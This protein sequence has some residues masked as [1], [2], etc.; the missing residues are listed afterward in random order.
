MLSSGSALGAPTCSPSRPSVP[1]RRS[2]PYP[3]VPG[4]TSVEQEYLKALVFQASSMDS[5]LPLEIEIAERFIAH[6]L[7]QFVFYRRSEAGQRVLGGCR[8]AGAAEAP[9]RLAAS[10]AQPAFFQCRFSAFQAGSHA[11]AG[12]TRRGAG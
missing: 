6:F 7:P 9:R 8:Q 4:E 3:A 2:H 10:C 1:A 5:L 12:G 11:A